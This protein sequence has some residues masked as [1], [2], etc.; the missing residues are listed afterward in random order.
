MVNDAESFFER[1][2]RLENDRIILLPFSEQFEEGLSRIIYGDSELSRFSVNCRSE[3]DLNAYIQRTVGEREKRNAYPFIVIDKTTNE[4]AGATRFGNIVFPNKRLEIGWTWYGKAYRGKGLNKACKY[5]LLKYAFEVMGF[6][7][8]QMSADID[9]VQS[10]RAIAKLG[11]TKE[12]VFRNNYI[13]SAGESRD[14][15][16]YSIV[17][18]EWE[19]IKRTVFK[20]F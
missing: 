16:Y 14:D 9:N 11:A 5:E 12:G 19:Y 7:R 18:S 13:N 4:V 10:Q 3:S 8:V 15:V 20:G 1:H 17:A 6:Q 2:I